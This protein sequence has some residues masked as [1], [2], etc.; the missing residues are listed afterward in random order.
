MT[1]RLLFVFL[2]SV[3][4]LCAEAAKAGPR[5]GRLLD[6]TPLKTEFVVGVDRH[7]ELITYDAAMTA[8][9]AGGQVFTVVAEPASGKSTVALEKTVNGF[10]SAAPLPLGDPYRV[11]V[12]A[13]SAEG[14][15]PKNF[16]VELNL[17][18]CAECNHPEY[19]CTCEDH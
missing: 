9:P 18:T 19:A 8:A 15:P 11:V 13:R 2:L 3:V 14:A 16:R 4:P 6:T 10:R 12:Q 17:T 1:F 5:G 7:L